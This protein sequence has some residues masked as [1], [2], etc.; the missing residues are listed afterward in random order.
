MYYP[1]T[2]LLTILE[3]LQANPTLS[4][5]DLA[6]RMEVDTRTV[7]RYITM[8]QDMGMPIEAERGRYGGYRLCPGYKLPPLM[9]NTDEAMAL[10]LGLLLTKRLGLGQAAPAAELALNKIERV[11]PTAIRQQVQAIQHALTLEL[12]MPEVDGPEPGLIIDLSFAVHRA[13]QIRL[14]YKSWSGSETERQFDPYGIIYRHGFWYTAGYCH[15]RQALRTF[16]LDRMV[17]LSILEDDFTPPANFDMV[18]HVEQAIAKTPGVWPVK[19]LLATSLAEAKMMLPPALATLEAHDEGV[20]LTCQIQNL[21]WFA[22][23]LA[24][25]DCDLQIISPPELRQAL[26]ELAEKVSRMASAET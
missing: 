16:R 15:L 21:A 13:R 22:H 20:M 5:K 19:V 12:Q 25:L 23:L 18:E 3:L 10:T 1:A 2:R 9:F 7:R 4:G 26:T 6:A 24:G 14:V 8:L 17:R 11:L